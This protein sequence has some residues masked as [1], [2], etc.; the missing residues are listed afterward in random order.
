ML[1]HQRPHA[2]RATLALADKDLC[3]ETRPTK[4]LQS[5]RTTSRITA[6]PLG[7]V[8]QAIILRE[9]VVF[10]IVNANEK[11]GLVNVPRSLKADR[12]GGA[13][14]ARLFKGSPKKGAILCHK[15]PQKT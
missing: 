5:Y 15:R 2:Q 4:G 11:R 7:T 1:K 13:R 9:P 6:F 12:A 8:F 10:Q 14:N 3:T